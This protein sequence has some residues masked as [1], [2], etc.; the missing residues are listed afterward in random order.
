MTPKLLSIPLGIIMLNSSFVFCQDQALYEIPL[1][2]NNLLDTRHIA[3]QKNIDPF[4]F[5]AF[6]QNEQQQKALYPISNLDQ[7]KDDFNAIAV[8]SQNTPQAEISEPVNIYI[9]FEVQK[10]NDGGILI[11]LHDIPIASNVFDHT[12]NLIFLPTKYHSDQ[13]AMADGAIISTLKTHFDPKLYQQIL[14]WR[15]D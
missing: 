13:E 1:R 8:I 11:R 3:I 12:G 15:V 9:V 14:A 7:F 5:K 6:Y 2:E 4:F 10:V